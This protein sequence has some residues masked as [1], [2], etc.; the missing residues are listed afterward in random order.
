MIGITSGQRLRVANKAPPA[1]IPATRERTPR[2][3]R[4]Q[5]GHQW[6]QSAGKFLCKTL[7]HTMEQTMENGSDSPA[8]SYVPFEVSTFPLS[9]RPQSTSCLPSATAQDGAPCPH[10]QRLAWLSSSAQQPSV[11][12][13]ASLGNFVIINITCCYYY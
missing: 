10:W 8:P 1:P 3:A 4:V 6:V 7:H 5:R 12:L 11:A 2:E 9:L 13:Q